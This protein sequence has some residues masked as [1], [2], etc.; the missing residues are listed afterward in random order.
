M[1]CT[2]SNQ[3]E[4]DDETKNQVSRAER[5]RVMIPKNRPLPQAHDQTQLDY[6]SRYKITRCDANFDLAMEIKRVANFIRSEDEDRW[7][8]VV[9]CVFNRLTDVARQAECDDFL[10]TAADVVGR[11]RV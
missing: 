11:Y 8:E 6:E 9:Q 3:R 7:I 2:D 10:R 5:Y 4:L 1:I